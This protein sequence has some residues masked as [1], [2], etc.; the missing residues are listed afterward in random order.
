MWKPFAQPPSKTKSSLSSTHDSIFFW[1][2]AQNSIAVPLP[3]PTANSPT[4]APAIVANS[5]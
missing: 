3:L 2:G 4:W 5:W 1:P